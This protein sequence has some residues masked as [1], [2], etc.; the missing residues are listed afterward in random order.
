MELKFGANT[1]AGL[2]VHSRS[3]EIRTICS[4]DICPF[5][6]SLSEVLSPE[7]N[8]REHEAA[9]GG[10]WEISSCCGP[11]SYWSTPAPQEV[12]PGDSGP[13]GLFFL[14]LAHPGLWGWGGLWGR[15]PGTTWA[16]CIAEA[17][18]I[19]IH[20]R[21]QS[22]SQGTE[23]RVSCSASGYPTPHISWSREGHALQE[24]SR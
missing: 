22:F 13:W 24:D 18:Q 8:S 1:W 21:S 14:C 23:V 19:G 12:T 9:V 11:G 20:T 2:G 17:P 15:A 4:P 6:L 16:F 3:L 10:H 5:S 7:Q